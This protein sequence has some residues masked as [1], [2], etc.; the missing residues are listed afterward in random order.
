[1]FCRIYLS[2]NNVNVHDLRTALCIIS[3]G[4]IAHNDYIEKNGYSMVIR[5][6]DEYDEK[7]SRIFPDGF[8]YFP[9]SIELDI[10]D[11][12]D[13]MQAAAEVNKI[14]QYLWEN[15]YS[16]IASCDFEDLLFEKGGYKSKNVPWT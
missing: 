5:A 3:G 13:R 16:A 15:S 8:L 12:I 2:G 11:V 4:V 10:D 9:Y 6:N 14:L 1:M 7:K